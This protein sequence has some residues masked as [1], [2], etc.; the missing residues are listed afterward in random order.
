MNMRLIGAP[1]LTDVTEDMVDARAVTN[2]DVPPGKSAY[3][4]NCESTSSRSCCTR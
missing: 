2:H 4:S 3:H 1:T